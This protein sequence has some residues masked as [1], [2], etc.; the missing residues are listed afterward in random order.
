MSFERIFLQ[1]CNCFVVFVPQT[2]KIEVIKYLKNI[3]S[4]YAVKNIEAIFDCASHQSKYPYI[5]VNTRKSLN[6][7]TGLSHIRTDIFNNN[8]VFYKND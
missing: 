7:S 3:L 8:I 1:N 6:D 4:Q 2:H 5:F